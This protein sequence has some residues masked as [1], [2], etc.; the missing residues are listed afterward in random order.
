M[1]TG[2]TGYLDALYVSPTNYASLVYMFKE[3]Y[4]G[5]ISDLYFQ[6]A[7]SDSTAFFY[8]IDRNLFNNFNDL[9]YETVSV[10]LP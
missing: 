5:K 8:G 3:V 4:S 6:T 9:Q 7:S 2:G 10:D 1:P